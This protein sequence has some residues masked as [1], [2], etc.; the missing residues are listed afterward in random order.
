MRHCLRD[1]LAGREVRDDSDAGGV[2][3]GPLQSGGTPTHRIHP[4]PLRLTEA[5]AQAG[6]GKPLC[7]RQTD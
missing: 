5:S 3:S 2:L 7:S 1:R 4:R 6:E